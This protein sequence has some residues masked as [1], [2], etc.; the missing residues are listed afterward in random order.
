[1]SS[2]F[3]S[4]IDRVPAAPL[5][6]AACL[7]WA[8]AFAGVKTGLQYTDPLSFAGMRFF[9]AGLILLPFC[10]PPLRIV[11]EIGK[12]WKV[13]LTVAFFQTVLLYS[14]FFLSMDMVEAS[15]GAIVNGISPLVGA[16]LAHFLLAGEGNRLTARKVLSFVIAVAGIVFI[17]AGKGDLSTIGGRREILGIF[18]MLAGSIS[19]AFASIYIARKKSPINPVLLNSLQISTGGVVLFLLSLIS[20]SFRSDIFLNPGSGFFPALIYLAFLSAT[21]FSIWFYLLKDRGVPVPTLSIWKFI[22]PV[23]GAI[24]SWIV[25]PGESPDY[26]SLSGMAAIGLSVLLFF[27]GRKAS[28][29]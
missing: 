8:T 19:S 23:T 4:F 25:I 11:R 16:L 9:L 6:V 5:A 24:F 18:L 20:G 17:G 12:Y 10:G 15:T 3:K 22:I 29:T 27:S 7:L 13:I 2:H 28:S 21:A 1:M 26:L 14:L